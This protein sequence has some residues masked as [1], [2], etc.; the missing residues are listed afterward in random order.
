MSALFPS[1]REAID[2]DRRFAPYHQ[3]MVHSWCG[4]V[5]LLGAIL[6]PL[7]LVLDWF[8]MPRELV[9]RF[10]EYR[11]VTTGIV[12]LQLVVI[13]FTRAARFS[14][15][16]GYFFTL[17]VGGMIALMTVDLGGFDSSYYAGLNLVI[18]ANLLIP[19]RAWHAAVNSI[20]TVLT[21][22]VLNAIWG[23]PFHTASMVNNLFFL[24]GSVVIAIATSIAKFG[25]VRDEFDARLELEDANARLERSRTDLKAARD[26]LWG[27]MEMAKRIQTALLPQN[28]RVGRYDVAARMMPAAEVGGDYYDIIEAGAGR[29]WVAI[30]DVSGHGVESGLV[31]MM[32]QTSI[33]S[34]VRENPGL[35]PAGVFREVNGVLLENIS[36]LRASR[37]MTLNVVQLREEGLLL[38]GKHQDLLVWRRGQ[39]RVE[40]VSNEGCWIGVVED[41]GAA[42]VDQTVALQEGDVALFY[43]DGATE[44]MDARGEMFG[45]GRLMAALAR[46]AER[47]LDEALEALFA[48]IEGF[49]AEQVD[50][51]T[52]LLV[53]K[54]A[55]AAAGAGAAGGEAVPTPAPVRR[56]A[57]G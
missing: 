36:R 51:V 54:V 3:A 12:V 53:R 49:R 52:L 40:A 26:A 56:G 16:H 33:L 28:R 2:P 11:G 55:P 30:G 44:A 46:V 21:Y 39:G 48:E 29:Y 38:A 27:E 13:R 50:D 57:G 4:T 6:V 35:T 24:G 23:G 25:L 31:M 43:T 42:A 34:L 17:L 22:V 14:F 19:W 15:L 37:Y 8:T 1:R 10:A 9:P 18:A 5:S 20:S 32:T 41:P 45:E 7:F 47:P